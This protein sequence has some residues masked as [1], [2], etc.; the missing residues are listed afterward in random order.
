F[1]LVL[2]N[3]DYNTTF[4]A[5]PPPSPYL[6]TTLPSLGR[7][8]THYYG[9]GHNS[10]GNYV[11]MVS[12]QAPN[13]LTQGDCPVYA[14]FLGAATDAD[15]Q[16]V[17]Q[18]CVY[19]RGV[20]T[21]GDQLAA[22]GRT[23]RVYAEDM[24]GNPAAPA[25]CRHPPLNGRDQWQ[26]G[27]PNDQYATRHVPFVYFHSV[28]D[29]QASCEAHVVDLGLL[30]GDLASAATTPDYAF[31]VPDVCSDG[32][33]DP[34]A[35]PRQKGGYAG[36]DEF[37]RAW[38]PR[39]L[40]SAAYQRDGLLVVTFDE[41]EASA[42]EACCGEPAGPNGPQPGITG[43]GGG[44]TGAVLLSPCLDPGTVDDTPHNHYSLLR[45]TED[46]WGLPHL[47]YAGKA[48]LQPIGL[49]RCAP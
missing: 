39:I 47:G 24:A 7:L 10:L 18:G 32:H 26:G 1:V 25:A 41:A 8:L 16:A 2:E 33:D 15:G 29:D 31:I 45:T 40:G 30:P 3:E 36:I 19:P 38:V 14:D 23:W 21:I 42:P 48:G 13:P 44:R 35:S 4:A 17:G 11:A 27:D 22:A 12:G 5:T 49:G 37:L 43:P 20:Q 6:A 46:V 28:V 34:C 9:I